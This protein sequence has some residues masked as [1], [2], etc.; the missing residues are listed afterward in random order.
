MLITSFR[1]SGERWAFKF[2]RLIA[3]R[4]K[5]VWF[6]ML[7]ALPYVHM[8][9]LYRRQASK[10]LV[11]TRFYFSVIEFIWVTAGQNQLSGI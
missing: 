6:A 7:G 5:G 3:I 2:F 11:S 9:M 1:E 10:H 4:C 8:H